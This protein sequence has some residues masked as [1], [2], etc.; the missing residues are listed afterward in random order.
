MEVEQTALPGIGLRHE[1][2]TRS[3]R[4]IGVVSHRTGRRDLVI[5]DADDPDRA[6]ETVKLNDEEANALAELLGAAAH[7]QRLERPAPRRS[8]AWSAEQLPIAPAPRTTDGRWATRR[9]RTRT[10]ASIVAVVRGGAGDRQPAPRLRAGRP[11]TSWSSWAAAEGTAAVADDPGRRVGRRVHMQR[12]CS[13]NSARSS[14]GSA[15]LGALALRFGISP[16]PLYLIAGLAFGHR[17]HPPAGHQ[18]GVHLRRR[19]AR[20]HPAAVHARPGVHRRRAG[21]AACGATPAAGLV[22]LV[23]N[24]APGVDRRAAARLGTGGRGRD[25]RRHLRHLLRHHR[26]GAGRPGLDR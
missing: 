2:T 6:C 13:W 24:A 7:R 17:R 20:R 16:I 22:D 26:Q 5:Y 14:S 12:S 11:A 10:G 25:G 21:R 23:L 1:F 18:R 8:R 15:L 9:V 3:G 4:R 19:R